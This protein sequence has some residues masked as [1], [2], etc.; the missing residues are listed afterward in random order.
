MQ[1]LVYM[2]LFSQ[3]QFV[4]T[5]R[6]KATN[7]TASRWTGRS[8]LCSL[9]VELESGLWMGWRV[10]SMTVPVLLYLST[11][12]PPI[13]PPHADLIPLRP[14]PGLKQWQKIV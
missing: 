12:A 10:V 6:Q 13:S 5:V 9:Q 8:R 7:F 11:P 14:L 1:L 2:F 3:F 4:Q